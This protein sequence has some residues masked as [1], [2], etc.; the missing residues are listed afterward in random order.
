M[1]YSLVRL[2][3]CIS[4][5]DFV[6]T[7]VMINEE[8]KTPFLYCSQN[9]YYWILTH[10]ISKIESSP[11]N[12]MNSSQEYID[13]AVVLLMQIKIHYLCTKNKIDRDPIG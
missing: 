3:E 11:I 8:F 5:L 6:V 13:K 12:A 9:Q 4:N 7:D 10:G 1:A 2:G